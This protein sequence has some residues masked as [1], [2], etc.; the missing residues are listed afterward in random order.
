MEEQRGYDRI[1]FF[2]DAVVAI[3]V[4]L[5]I[6][7][8]VET[9]SEVTASGVRDLLAEDRNKLLAFALSFVVISL[10]WVVHHQIF[11][12]LIGYNARLIW[13]NFVWLASIVFLPFPTA[14]IA[15]RGETDPVAIGIYIGTLAVTSGAALLMQVLVLRSP[16]LQLESVRGTLRITSFAISFGAI[17]LALV[18]SLA[19]PGIGL[20]G[21]L[22]LIPSAWLQRG[23]HAR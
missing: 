16:Q 20:Y 4:T 9:T 6:L 10:Y 8:L 18:L 14:L 7:P 12:N 23:V 5:L 1:V 17:V 15:V 3:A 19:V 2:S 13:A 22:L 11:R 21:L